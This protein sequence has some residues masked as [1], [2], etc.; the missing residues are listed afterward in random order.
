MLDQAAIAK[1]QKFSARHLAISA[2]C[3]LLTR[4]VILVNLKDK[5]IDSLDNPSGFNVRKLVDQDYSNL[6]TS[7]ETHA[8]S[9]FDKFVS[10]ILEAI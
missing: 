8:Q 4:D 3:I 6:L 7:L 9:I 5:L 1:V 10:I 2:N